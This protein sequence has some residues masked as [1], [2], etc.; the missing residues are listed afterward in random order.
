MIV[1]GALGMYA[2]IG[3]VFALAFVTRGIER[4]DPAARETGVGFRLLV[5]PGA[6]ALWPLLL[7]KWK[8]AKP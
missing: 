3:F 2:L 7:R 5:I 8:E 4:V 1:A 6:A